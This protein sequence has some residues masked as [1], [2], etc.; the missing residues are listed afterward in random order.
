MTTKF[1]GL[2]QQPMTGRTFGWE[3]I[4]NFGNSSL[5]SRDIRD[6]Q[7]LRARILATISFFCHL[8]R[9][10]SPLGELAI[11]VCRDKSAMLIPRCLDRVGSRLLVFNPNQLWSLKLIFF[12][13]WP[14]STAKSRK[15][16]ILINSSIFKKLAGLDATFYKSFKNV[17][18]VI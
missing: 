2:L 4:R 14:V 16:L 10:V 15:N 13:S 7:F 1:G 3:K 6:V 12:K 9:Q 5:K 11:L 17:L 8:P 18:L